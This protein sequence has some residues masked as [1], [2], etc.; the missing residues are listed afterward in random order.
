VG[1]EFCVLV[2]LFKEEPHCVQKDIPSS[3][4]APQEGQ[5]III[6]PLNFVS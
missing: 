1:Y 3:I 2:K 4:K 6:T 5:N